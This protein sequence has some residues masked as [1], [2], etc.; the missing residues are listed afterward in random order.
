ME[1]KYTRIKA[2]KQVDEE[3]L[4]IVS[5]S[6]TDKLSS[7]RTEISKDVQTS[8]QDLLKDLISCLDVLKET[9]ECLTIKITK[10]HGQP[11]LIT[12]TWTVSKEYHGK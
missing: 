3:T 2:V 9:D 4:E 6:Y 12:K 1:L 11:R 8:Q 5:T 10:K 7:V